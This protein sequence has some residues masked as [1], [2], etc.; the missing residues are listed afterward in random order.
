VTALAD[1][2]ARGASPGDALLHAA[3][4]GGPARAL[5]EAARH[6]EEEP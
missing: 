4:T 5:R 6:P 1:L 3:R 2:V